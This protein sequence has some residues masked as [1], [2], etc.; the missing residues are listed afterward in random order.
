MKKIL[1][2]LAVAGIAVLAMA[3][4]VA[5]AG[6]GG[7]AVRERAQ[8]QARAT[9]PA[10]LGL[11]AAE[12]EELRADG[13]SLAQIAE[14][15]GV[16]PQDLVDALMVR[17]EARIQARLELGA[18]TPDEATQLRTQLET[19]ARDLVFKV[20]TGGMQGAAVG[21]GPNGPANGAANGAA[22]DGDQA[23]QRGASA[24]QN[25]D[26]T[27]DGSGD[28]GGARGPGGGARHRGRGARA[29]PVGP[30]RHDASG[31]SDLS[32]VPAV[33][34]CS[35]HGPDPGRRRRAAHRG[36]GPRLPRARGP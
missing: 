5:A 10:I 14:R 7:A 32:R 21:A 18:L 35:D 30:D 28:G 23:R 33:L 31:R 13:L 19:R 25:G 36:R 26:G 16:D 6:P 11:S 1:T 12:V 27:C 3:A 24:G 4:T 34:P 15:E 17:W 29:G 22:G 8:E 20:T 2:A 9:T